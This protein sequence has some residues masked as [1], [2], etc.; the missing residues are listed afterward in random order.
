MALHRVEQRGVA[1]PLRGTEYGSKL[2]DRIDL[3]V[4]VIQ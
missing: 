1:R 4:D 3:A 2:M